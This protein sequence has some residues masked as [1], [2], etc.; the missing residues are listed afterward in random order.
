MA[1][2]RV[3]ARSGIAAV[4]TAPARRKTT[5]LVPMIRPL[6][7]LSPAPIFWPSRIVVPM[8]K[9]LMRL[10][11]VCMIWEPTATPDTSCA[12]PYFPTTSRSTA[13]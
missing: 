6:C 5:V 9:E 4:M 1:P 2:A 12:S 7:S 10:V 11:I 3:G 8:A 13:P